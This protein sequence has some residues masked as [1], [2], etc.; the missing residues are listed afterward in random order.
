MR[1]ALLVLLLP[2]M[3]WGQSAPVTTGPCHDDGD[4]VICE[5]PGFDQITAKCRGYKKDAQECAVRLDAAQKYAADLE[6]LIAECPVCPTC[7]QPVPPP[8]QSGQRQVWGYALGIVGTAAVLSSP[9]F[10]QMGVGA[11]A[12]TAIT[13]LTLV[14]TGFIV[15]LTFD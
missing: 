14:T 5:R 6:K 15:N 10:P 9:L 7:Q 12:V 2:A 13:G 3:A 4:Y 8:R 11:Q 1:S